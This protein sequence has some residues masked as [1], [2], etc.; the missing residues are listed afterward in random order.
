MCGFIFGN[1]SIDSMD[2]TFCGDKAISIGET[3]EVKM[4]GNIINS[5]TGV[6]VKDY[7]YAILDQ[8]NIAKLNIVIKFIIK[9]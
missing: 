7:S 8:I 1:Y 5:N 9:S 6:A 3:S 2:L 4:K